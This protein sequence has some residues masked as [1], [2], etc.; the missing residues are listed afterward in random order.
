MNGG[1][2]KN[3]TIFNPW[4]FTD[5]REENGESTKHHFVSTLPNYMAFG[6]GKHAW[7]EIPHV[8]ALS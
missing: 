7:Y 2:Y 5:M 6:H 4:R 1:I 8:L 3:P